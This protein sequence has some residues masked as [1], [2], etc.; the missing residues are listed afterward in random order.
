MTPA[1]CSLLLP[2]H[3]ATGGEPNSGK[4]SGLRW[5]R[6]NQQNK[7]RDQW[8]I[9]MKRETARERGINPKKQK[10]CPTQL[11]TTL[12]PVPSLSLMSS[13]QLLTNL[14]TLYTDHE[15]LHGMEYPFGK[16]GSAVLAV[17]PPSFLCTC[18]LPEHGRLKILDLGSALLSN[19]QSISVLPT[20]FPY[21]IQST[22]LYQLLGRKVAPL[23]QLKAG[24]HYKLCFPYCSVWQELGLSIGLLHIFRSNIN[25][26]CL[27]MMLS[28]MQN[29]LLPSVLVYSMYR[30]TVIGMGE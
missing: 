29:T 25:M 6:F 21:W 7:I 22:A 28:F 12:W 16:F 24:H 19:S 2:P 1:A 5:Q 30:M 23:S 20:L 17:L 13:Q 4:T 27:V 9:A 14:P 15:M 3:S 26:H 10:W 18:S 11:L 8:S